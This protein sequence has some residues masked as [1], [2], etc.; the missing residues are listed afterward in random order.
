MY[1]QKKTAVKGLCSLDLCADLDQSA[2][3]V[4]KI[5]FMKFY[6]SCNRVM[7][8]VHASLY[9]QHIEVFILQIL[10]Y[11]KSLKNANTEFDRK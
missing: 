9:P 2:R 3:H 6:T 8:P 4:V 11:C 1:G 5:Q 7:G 10:L